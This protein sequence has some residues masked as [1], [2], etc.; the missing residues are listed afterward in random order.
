MK[1]LHVVASFYHF[2]GCDFG[3][4]WATHQII[5]AKFRH[6]FVRSLVFY[7]FPT[8]TNNLDWN[9]TQITWEQ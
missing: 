8:T 7:D 5:F 4:P 3:P 9:S 6:P 1:R 2:V